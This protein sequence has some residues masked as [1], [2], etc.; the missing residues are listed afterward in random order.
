MAIK[1]YDEELAARIRLHL[2]ELPNLYEK[3]MFGGLVFIYNDNI[4]YNF[5]KG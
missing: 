5:L 3:E 1:K 4:I 2:S